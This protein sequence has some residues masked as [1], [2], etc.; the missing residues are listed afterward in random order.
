[1]LTRTRS[2]S[3][4]IA[5]YLS[6]QGISIISSE[7]LLVSNSPEVNFINA[8][9]EFSLTAEDKN[10]KWNI[11][12]Y[13]NK[14]LNIENPH[15][16]FE[17]NLQYDGSWFFEWL[18]EYG[19]S[20]DLAKLKVLTLYEA[21]EYII[22]SFSLIE[23]SD[24]YLQFYLDF[25]FEKTSKNFTGIP[26]YLELWEQEAGKLS[27]VA[28]KTE[29][30]V[31]IMTIHKSKGLEFPVVIYPFANTKLR[32]VSRDYLWVPLPENLDD[33]PVGYLKASEKMKNWGEFESATFQQRVDQTEFD[34]I[35]ILYVAFTRASQQLYVISN[36]ELNSKGEEDEKKVSGL[37]I[38]FLKSMQL[39]NESRIYEFGDKTLSNYKK[40]FAAETIRQEKYYSSPT[41]SNAVKLMTSSGVLWGSAREEAIKRGNLIHDILSEIDTSEDIQTALEK[42]S[43]KENLDLKET[44]EIKE[45]LWQ[46]ISHPELSRYFLKE[47]KIY[48]ERDIISPD[49]ELLRPDR[50]IFDGKLVTIMDY[51]TG[52]VSDSHIAQ[53]NQYAQVL[54]LMN[55]EVTNKILVYINEEVNLTFV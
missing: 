28:P 35:N 36:Y 23:K 9:F 46:V 15:R 40:E 42:F 4:A 22:R 14:K 55:F 27:I 41:T 3:F 44:S 53:M 33:I 48:R 32:D 37:L 12:N 30:A 20:F 26:A 13:L 2:Q 38:G 16:N 18:K 10:L 5:H 29:H 49:G 51:K 8:I 17:Q 47:L 1:M 6:E 19:I 11:L 24:A 52:N 43:E 39:W 25:I 50:L 34:N 54:S 31:Q 21:A 7:S 45:N